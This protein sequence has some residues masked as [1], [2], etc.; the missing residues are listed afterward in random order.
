MKIF[1]VILLCGLF[2]L[3]IA[4]ERVQKEKTGYQVATVMEDITFKEARNQYL[5][6]KI[7]V[8]KSPHKIMAAAE[9]EGMRIAAPSEVIVLKDKDENA[10]IK[11]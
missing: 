2:L 3:L 10:E 4:M 1:Y 7:G 8:Y 11:N 5:R 6:Y 9:R